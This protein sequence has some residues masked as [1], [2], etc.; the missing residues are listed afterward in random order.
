M[1]TITENE[2]DLLDYNEEEDFEDEYENEDE[3][4][5]EPRE[6][7]RRELR[8]PGKD[9]RSELDAVTAERDDLKQRLGEALRVGGQKLK[10]FEAEVQKWA[11]NVQTWHDTQVEDARDKAFAEGVMSV[12]KRLLPLLASEEKADYLAE[13]RLSP[14]TTSPREPVRLDPR[15]ARPT[16]DSKSL[17]DAVNKFVGMGVPLDQLDQS[18]VGAVIESGTKAMQS[19][20][21]AIEEKLSSVENRFERRRRDESGATRVS[22]GGGS[23]GGRPSTQATRLQEQL[24][25]I[26]NRIRIAKSSHNIDLGTRLLAERREILALMAREERRQRARG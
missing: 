14:Q 13:A 11:D 18:S 22:S 20:F 10:D 21:D 2:E 5:I 1:V 25:E 15:P 16:E 26:D 7:R 4:E 23:S 6:D 19:R 12:E 9:L 24:D 3:E 17:T 8:S